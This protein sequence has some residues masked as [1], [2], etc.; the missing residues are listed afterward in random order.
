MMSAPCP[1]CGD[2]RAFPLWATGTCGLPGACPCD[3]EGI[4]AGRP[5]R[6]HNVAECPMQMRRAHMQA[7]RRRLVPDAYDAAGN[8]LPGQIYRVMVAYS[9]AHPGERLI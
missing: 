1:V 3:D 7:E 5:V 2:P 8:I 6:I 9:R 4:S